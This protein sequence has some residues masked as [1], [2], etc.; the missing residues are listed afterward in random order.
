MKVIQ[1]NEVRFSASS[2][3]DEAGKVFFFQEKAFRAIYSKPHAEL[4]ADMLQRSW[5]DELFESGLVNTRVSEEIS[6]Q[7]S[8]LTLEHETIPFETHPA[9]HTNLMHWLAAKAVVKVN[10][11]LS[12]YGLTLKDAHP[13]NVMFHKGVAKVIDF[14]SITK[15]SEISVFWLEEFRKYFCVP[16]WLASTR[17]HGYSCEYRR[18]HTNGF[19]LK[20][21]ENKYMNRFL[22][23]RLND[24]GKCIS[25]LSDYFEQID[26]WLEKHKPL[27]DKKESWADY[28]QCGDALNP[29]E[30]V[31]PK[32]KFVY[33]ILSKVKP[34][35]VLDFA[36]N[37]GY[38]S[39][40]AAK[41]GAAVLAC[42]YEEYCVDK[43]LHLA[44]NKELAVTPALMDFRM[45]TPEY[46][47]G[48]SGKNS[49]VRFNSDIVLALGLVHHICI[50]QKIPVDVF[51]DICMG[52]AK[53]GVILEFIDPA[54]KHVANWGLPIP[55]NYSI[56]GLSGI[57]GRKFP[58][59]SQS[60][61]IT[62]DGLARTMVY[63]Y[64]D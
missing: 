38:Y 1:P 21:F 15:S 11:S 31:H 4:Y 20:L 28:E 32:Q 61:P 29:L 42:D 2:I 5:I 13:W 26:D 19:G 63:F 12:K 39:E 50:T 40:M 7:G 62:H 23:S 43:C 8:F 35:K 24:N 22:F 33:E 18:Q 17:W 25:N 60:E 3:V 48:L 34:T 10:H 55:I 16:I 54:D 9:E 6:L 56:E 30:P 53:E 37:K 44:Q 57:F 51:C 52:Y 64:K 45:P 59:L 14:G 36:A 49:Y 47:L 46:G 41:L 58:R 27:T